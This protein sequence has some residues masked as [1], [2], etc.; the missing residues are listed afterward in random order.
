MGYV[1]DGYPATKAQ[2]VA[3]ERA[4][5]GLD[6]DAEEAWLAA[7]SRIAPP[8][9]EYTSNLHRALHSGLDH[10]VVLG[11]GEEE[12]VVKRAVGRRVDPES[13]V[14][15]HLEFD[16]PP[17]DQPGHTD[18]LTPV[19]D[20]A[21]DAVQVQERLATHVAEAP[22]LDQWL[23][24]FVKLRCGVDASVPA[25]EVTAAA[26]KIADSLLKAKS[27]AAAANAGNSAATEALAAAEAARAQVMPLKK[28]P[29]YCFCFGFCSRDFLFQL[30]FILV[31]KSLIEKI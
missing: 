17:A 29:L 12:T 18:R 16:P 11:L 4:L 26:L 24:R 19:E 1:L 20:A 15:Y 23:G 9:P 8:P 31:V 10:V 25:A 6:L 3:L 22:G 30:K 28:I 2:S 13:G 21:Y 14:I 7:A 5:T 27:A